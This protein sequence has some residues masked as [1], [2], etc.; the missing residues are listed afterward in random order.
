MLDL[1]VAAC[2]GGHFPESLFGI[3]SFRREGGVYFSEP[4]ASSGR[5]RGSEKT[6]CG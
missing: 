5:G 1:E 3:E 4:G 6:S 2:P